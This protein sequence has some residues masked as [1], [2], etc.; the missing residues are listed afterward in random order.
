MNLLIEPNSA[1]LVALAVALVFWIGLFALLWRLDVRVRELRRAF[2]EQSAGSQTEPR[3]ILGAPPDGDRTSPVQESKNSDHDR[4][5]CRYWI[6]W[7]RQ[8][9]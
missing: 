2:D 6:V 8:P 1:E 7:T 3:A 4:L 5:Q 9:A